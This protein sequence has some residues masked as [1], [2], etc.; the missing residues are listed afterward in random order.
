MHEIRANLHLHT[1]F[2]DG[3]GTHQQVAEAAIRSG[4]DAVL[5]SDHNVWVDGV[6]GYV[7]QGRRKVLVVIGEELHDPAALPQRNHMLVFG[8]GREL[9]HLSGQWQAVIDEV[10]QNGGVSFLA[11]PFEDA[12]PVIKE[13][14]IPWT[15]W[16]IRGYTGIELWNGFSELKTVSKNFGQLLFHVFFPATYPLGP[17]RETLELWDRLLQ[18][19][20][21]V[22]AVGGAD[23]HALNYRAGPLRKR[24]FPYEFH[25]H[26][27]NTHVLLDEPFSGDAVTDRNALLAALRHGHCFVAYDRPS[28]SDGFRFTGQGRNEFARM[29]DMLI[30]DGSVTFQI[31][32][33]HRA[34]C[35]L[36]KDGS[37]VRAWDDREVCTHITD[38]P[39]VYRAEAYLPYLGKRRGW[40]YSNPIYFRKKARQNDEQ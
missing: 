7:R 22:T 15:D 40:I 24:I 12:L 23:A 37:P 19:G 16:T 20:N 35:R 21:Q 34:E 10:D 30:T 8:A 17:K 9:S 32:L 5:I 1:R 25:F 27:V 38:E 26:S 14:A 39:G 33:P 28:P 29:G 18:A 3:T 2:S 13:P 31:R 4:L 6:D 36:I 11:H